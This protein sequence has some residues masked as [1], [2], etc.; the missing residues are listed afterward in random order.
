MLCSW[1]VE[2]R[3]CLKIRVGAIRSESS[4][5][6]SSLMS[7]SS[8]MMI[9]SLH[10]CC[11]PK[12][13]LVYYEDDCPSHYCHKRWSQTHLSIATN[14][15]CQ[16]YR[17]TYKVLFFTKVEK[18]SW[19]LANA[20]IHGS[21]HGVRLVLLNSWG[22]CS[23][24]GCPLDSCTEIWVA[25]LCHALIAHSLLKILFATLIS[26]IS[27]CYGVLGWIPNKKW[28]M[29]NIFWGDWVTIN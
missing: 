1:I 16:S 6:R 13:D 18:Q 12:G 27:K 5:L 21:D 7:S 24:D 14:D 2:S 28:N 3:M 25:P 9:C 23:S 17:S 4:F 29:S 15:F 22:S 19:I 20:L 10:H 8:L 26:I 11:N